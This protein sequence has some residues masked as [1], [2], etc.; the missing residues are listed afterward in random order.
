MRDIRF[1]SNLV[2]T[3]INKILKTLESK[4]LVKAIKS[5]QVSC[6]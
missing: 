1:K 5:V 2:Q 3:Q 6:T 4:K